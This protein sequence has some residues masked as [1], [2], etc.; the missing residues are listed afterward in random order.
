[1][2]L[3]LI[4]RVIRDRRVSVPLIGLSVIAYAWLITSIWPIFSGNPA[5]K[6]LIEQ[7]PE[8]VAAFLLGTSTLA[9]MTPEG[10]LAG[11]FLQ[12]WWLVIVGSFAIVLGASVVGKDTDDKTMD[13][14]LT[15]PMRRMTLILSRFTA[16]AI[17]LLLLVVITMAA[18]WL[19]ARV[20]DMPIKASGFVAA[21]VAGY[22]VLLFF[23]GFSLFFGVVMERGRAIIAGVAVFVASQVLHGLGALNETIERLDWLSFMKYYD[24]L[25][26]LKTGDVPWRDVGLLLGLAV[27]FLTAAFVVFRRK[28]IP[29]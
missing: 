1:M 15:Q 3:N 22:S 19:G 11:E 24:P 5:L 6:Q 29:A 20:Y 14:L 17:I 21:G 23:E 25:K 7:Y 8:A 2:N 27:L 10:F 18:S 26:A 12:L 16:D 9:F 4:L 13:L 28:D